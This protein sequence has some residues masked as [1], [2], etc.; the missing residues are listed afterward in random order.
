MT[1][2]FAANAGPSPELLDALTAGPFHTALRFAIDARGLTLERL[3]HRLALRG[4]QVS[5]TSLSYWQ[6]GRTQPERPASLRAV[7]VLEEVL[8]VP[9]RSLADLLGPR[10]PRGPRSLRGAFGERPEDVM[11]IGAPLT[12]LFDQLSDSR[13]HDLALVSQHETV[14][15]DSAGRIAELTSRTLAESNRDGADRYFAV[16]QGDPG[17]DVRQVEIEA[18]RDCRIGEVRRDADALVVV[19]E[20][21][22]GAELGDGETH[23]FEFGVR[24]GTAPVTTSHGH[25]F[26]CRVGQFVL[27]AR[28]DPAAL[29]DR[30]YGFVQSRLDQLQRPTG[31]LTLN[32]FHA[33]HVAV[34]DV[35]AG[36]V[37]I[38]WTWP[39]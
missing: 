35:T 29:P 9:P 3:Q 26:R 17:C 25:G 24:D 23:L 4:I 16:Y 1:A 18:L 27:Q 2:E 10:R 34:A 14:T 28:F 19:A 21:L 39:E 20:L 37:G 6:H 32:A 13:R 8:G 11:G 15:L 38:G 31:D 12:A 36:G 7:G 33:A 30:C 5:V 22:F